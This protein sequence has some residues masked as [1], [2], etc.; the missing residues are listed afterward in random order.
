MIHTEKLTTEEKDIVLPMLLNALKKGTEDQPLVS[1]RIVKWFN[2]NKQQ[3]GMKT[4]FTS[5]RLRKLTN[6]C[7]TN[8]IAPIIANS[9]GYYISNKKKDLVELK[10][11]IISRIES[12]QAVV[13]GIDDMMNE[14]NL[15]EVEVD[16]L[17]FEW[18][19]KK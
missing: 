17:G 15:I 10:L 18:E 8:G 6:Y 16:C 12:L 2:D 14:L 19:V 13:K 3:I 5:S 11:S 9:K 4:N 1:D 7:R